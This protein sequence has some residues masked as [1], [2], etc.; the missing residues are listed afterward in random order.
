MKPKVEVTETERGSPESFGYQRA[1]QY[2]TQ[3]TICYERPDGQLMAFERGKTAVL[4][5][6]RGRYAKD[7]GCGGKAD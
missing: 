3:T 1:P 4:V 7:S 5:R 2:D 6:L